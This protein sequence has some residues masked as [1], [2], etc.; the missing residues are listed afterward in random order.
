M[1]RAKQTRKRIKEKY[2][3]LGASQIGMWSP[4]YIAKLGPGRVAPVFGG[5]S[6]KFKQFAAFRIGYGTTMSKSC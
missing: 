2:G 5:L 4:G 6:V 3:I 1:N